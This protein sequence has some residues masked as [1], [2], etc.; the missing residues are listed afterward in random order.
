MKK[1]VLMYVA[2]TLLSFSILNSSCKKEVQIIEEEEEIVVVEPSI[3]ILWEKKSDM[4]GERYGGD[5]VVC[6]DKIYHIGGRS[7]RGFEKSNFEYNPASDL[8]TTKASMGLE[9]MNLA[10]AAIGD[11]I[12]AIGGDP[13]LSK[14]EIYN[15]LTDDWS[16]GAHMPTPRQHV[17]CGVVN[18]KIYVIGGLTS[19]EDLTGI[20]EAYD[21]ATDTWETKAPMPTPRH[22]PAIIVYD[23]KIYVFGGAGSPI[24]IWS[25]LKTVEVY[26]PATDTWETKQSLPETRFK[27]ATAVI[28]DKIYVIGGFVTGVKSSRVDVYI[29]ETDT[30][31]QAT[32]FPKPIL[33]PG[34]V[35]LN[36]TIF[37]SGGST[38]PWDGYTS[39]YQGVLD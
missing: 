18:G 2:I 17:D 20:N 19:W 11:N 12:Y 21:P 26:D 1:S 37:V 5:A 8:W 35:S 13:F 25:Y 10:L 29:P 34:I 14:N 28:D 9:T 23:N 7:V 6:N 36:N 24:D 38:F 32:D 39:N 33:F 27:P 31:E 15:T 22:N 30:W 4:P 3:K 16:I